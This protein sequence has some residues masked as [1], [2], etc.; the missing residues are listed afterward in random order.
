MHQFNAMF[1]SKWPR[2]TSTSCSVK[3][4]FEE[5][6]FVFSATSGTLHFPIPSRDFHTI[7]PAQWRCSCLNW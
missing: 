7:G 2:Y 1:E 4:A 3:T 6:C 5:A